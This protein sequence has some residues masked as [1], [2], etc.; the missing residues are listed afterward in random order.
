MGGELQG[1]KESLN[2]PGGDEVH[3]GEGQ[4]NGGGSRVG[5]AHDEDEHGGA[6]LAPIAHTVRPYCRH[7]LPLM[8]RLCIAPQHTISAHRSTMHS[9]SFLRTPVNA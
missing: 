2:L 8:H 4:D 3:E 6:H 1:G 9:C 5:Q 7:V